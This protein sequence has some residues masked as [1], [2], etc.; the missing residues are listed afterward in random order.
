M[1]ESRG[2]PFNTCVALNTIVLESGVKRI[3]WFLMATAAIVFISRLNH[4]VIENYA[5]LP[6]F[7]IMAIVTRS[8]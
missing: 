7:G 3:A 6:P 1:I 8:R 5:R 2:D 4:I